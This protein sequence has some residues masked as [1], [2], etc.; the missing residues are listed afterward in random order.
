MTLH[1]ILTYPEKHPWI[2]TLGALM[3]IVLR[4]ALSLGVSAPSN[5]RIGRARDALDALL[6]LDLRKLL[7]QAVDTIDDHLELPHD[8]DTIPP[9]APDSAPV[10][11]GMHTGSPRTNPQCCERCGKEGL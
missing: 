8:A 4:V 3:A 10:A 11:H 1:D 6:P 9:A 7:D 5:T 2:T